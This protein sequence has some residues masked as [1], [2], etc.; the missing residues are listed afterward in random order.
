LAPFGSNAAEQERDRSRDVG[1]IEEELTFGYFARDIICR[2]CLASV[3]AVKPA[4]QKNGDNHGVS[5]L[6]AV[7]NKA[8]RGRRGGHSREKRRSSAGL[9]LAFSFERRGFSRFALEMR[10]KRGAVQN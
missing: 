4:A 8:I 1:E 10:S 2:F 6:C 9:G 7:E 3:L 5:L